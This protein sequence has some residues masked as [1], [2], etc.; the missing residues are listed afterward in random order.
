MKRLPEGRETASGGAVPGVQADAEADADADAEVPV[1]V[2]PDRV[3]VI[4]FA[5][6]LETAVP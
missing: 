1:T 2:D 3:S 5:D 4:V 6:H